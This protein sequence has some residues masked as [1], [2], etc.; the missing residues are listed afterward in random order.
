MATGFLG[1][2]PGD[3]GIAN[4]SIS[5]P[6]LLNYCLWIILVFHLADLSFS[7]S[8]VAEIR[9]WPQLLSGLAVG[10][11]VALLAGCLES[12][13][14]NAPWNRAITGCLYCYA[15]LQLAYLGFN[16]QPKP[17]VVLPP[18]EK[19]LSELATVTSPPTQAPANRLLLLGTQGRPAG[20]LHRE[21][22]E[23]NPERSF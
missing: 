12:E 3:D 21:N 9:F 2:L 11:C 17:K 14:L 5:L 20:I 19:Y 16:A 4:D 23:P 18:I 15:V 10:V 13:Y 7:L 1:S 22:Q 6:L 8:G